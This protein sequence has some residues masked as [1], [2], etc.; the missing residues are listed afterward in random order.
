M[1]TWHPRSW[2][3][4]LIVAGLIVPP[5]L[6]FAIGGIAVGTTMG[7]LMLAAL[8]VFAARMS[9]RGPIHFTGEASGQPVVVLAL[10]GV[11]DSASANSIATL[12]EAGAAERDPAEHSVLVLAPASTGVL[13]RWLSDTDES[14]IRAQQN[15]AI[16]LATLAAAG[17]HAEGRLVDADPIQA[18]EDVAA[19][20]GAERV[21]VVVDGTD[22]DREIEELD[23][24]I[25]RPLHRIE[26]RAD[27][28][29]IRMRET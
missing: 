28:P 25:D 4:P 14:R 26:V 20:Y 11:E 24:R 22:H 21:V 2:Q 16:S 18:V 10:A 15:L 8:V 9:H 13:Q 27:D 29:A 17:C 19:Q 5:F 23:K 6:G 12:A 7:A 3:L 1:E